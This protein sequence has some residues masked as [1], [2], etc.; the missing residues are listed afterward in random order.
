MA[1]IR[2]PLRRSLL[3]GTAIFIVLLCL[4]LSVT[5]YVNYRKQLYGR[6]EKF[7]EGVLNYAAAD[8]DADDLAQCIKTG[9]ESEK[10]HQLQTELDTIKER[11]DIRFIYVIVPINTEPNNNVK[12]VIA[13]ATRYE[14]EHEA[15]ELVRLNSMSGDAYTSD[16]AKK[17]MAA[18][19]AGGLSFFESATRW[20]DDYTGMLP[21]FDSR[22]D[23]VA[24][25]CVDVDIAQI[26]TSLR[27]NVILIAA[28]VF[29]L[30]L[31]F[32]IAILLWTSKNVTRP[33]GN[34][35]NCVEGFAAKCRDQKGPDELTM[36]EPRNRSES[37]VGA[38][39]E[40][41]VRLGG[42]VREYVRG[43]KHTEKELSKMIVAANRDELTSVRNTTAFEAF[44]IDLDSRLRTGGTQCAVLMIDVNDVA[45][46]NAAYGEEKGDEY[47]VNNCRRIC[48]VFDHSPVFR[49]GGDEFVVVLQGKDYDN[50][51]ALIEGM[52]RMVEEMAADG[53][54]PA[55]ERCAVTIGI[56]EYVPGMDD[57]V[58]EVV[59]R[60]DQDMVSEKERLKRAGKQA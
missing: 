28:L 38:L 10:Y 5:Q 59:R 52:R 31:A 14:Y 33:L 36:E 23:H 30:G 48:E 3:A 25:L 44:K 39:S 15:D 1:K 12:N 57:S 29:A 21:L 4:A 26:H 8:I 27:N 51:E 9:Q 19:Q 24:A 60:A 56:S 42:T 16:T 54:I 43:I 32:I 11:L 40:A 45:K 50:R 7:I 41:V 6:Y 46:V 49:F 34:L 35:E 58:E 13:G 53:S 37:E 22:G 2:K 17:Y 18:Y 55:W 47:I 20:G